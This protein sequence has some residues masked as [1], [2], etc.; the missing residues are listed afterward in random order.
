MAQ[1]S[2]SEAQRFAVY[3]GEGLYLTD[4]N[5]AHFTDKQGTRCNAE[6]VRLGGADSALRLSR[7][8]AVQACHRARRAGVSAGV[9]PA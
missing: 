3:S 7:G 2:A 1:S 6:Y 8:E 5:G 9:V 4:T